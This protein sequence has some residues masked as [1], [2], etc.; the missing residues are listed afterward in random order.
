MAEKHFTLEEAD[1]LLPRLEAILQQLVVVRR[2]MGAKQ[3]KME[4]L[5]AHV[6]GNGATA[7]GRA[8]A[9]LKEELEAM[10]QELREGIEQIEGLGCLVKDLDTGLID[11]PTLRQ[12]LE[13]LLCWKLGE[14]RIAFWHT[15]Q[16]GFAGR[17]HLGGEFA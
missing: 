9:K 12:G 3:H 8:F 13:V 4:E 6:R 16:E 5:R 11:F 14:E 7:E 1:R 10:A 17:K 2:E 15:T